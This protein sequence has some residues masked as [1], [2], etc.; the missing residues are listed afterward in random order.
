MT[1]SLTVRVHFF[2]VSLCSARDC[3]PRR[4]VDREPSAAARERSHGTECDA[5][6]LDARAP[7]RVQRRHDRCVLV[8]VCACLLGCVLSRMMYVFLRLHACLCFFS[9]VL[10]VLLNIYTCFPSIPCSAST[11]SYVIVVT[12]RHSFQVFSHISH[13]LAGDVY[14]I[15]GQSNAEFG[16]TADPTTRDYLLRLNA[17]LASAATAPHSTSTSNTLSE[18]PTSTSYALSVSHIRVFSVGQGTVAHVPLRE[19]RSVETPW[20]R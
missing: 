16:V 19:F 10:G 4:T 11:A 1:Q 15:G 12:S 20:S 18:S 7:R 14:I 6:S 13:P 5:G 8:L 17:S 2:A 9:T 3:W